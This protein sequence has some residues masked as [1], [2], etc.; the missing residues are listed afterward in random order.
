MLEDPMATFLPN[1]L[2]AIIFEPFQHVADLHRPNRSD[3]FMRL[4]YG[5]E[6]RPARCSG[7]LAQG[8]DLLEPVGDLVP[9]GWH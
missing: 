3:G 7:Q 5:L 4:L 2:P 6:D 8:L 1:N 9:T